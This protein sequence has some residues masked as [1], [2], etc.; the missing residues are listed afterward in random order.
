MIK[1]SKI[2]LLITLVFT[3]LI[4]LLF[5]YPKEG[6]KVFGYEVKFVSFSDYV[7]DVEYIVTN[8]YSAKKSTQTLK[9]VVVTDLDTNS[10]KS[11]SLFSADFIIHPSGFENSM[12]LFY[13]K[14]QNIDNEKESIRIVHFG[15]SQI[16]GDRISNVLRE[17]LQNE[18]GGC[19]V[20]FVPVS[21]SNFGKVTIN[22]TS[23]GWEKHQLFG[24]KQID[25][26]NSFGF[27]GYYH[28]I[29][30][31]QNHAWVKFSGSYNGTENSQKFQNIKLMLSN[32]Q[33]PVDIT[34]KTDT[35]TIEH[36]SLLKQE[37]IY[38]QE[39]K[40]E[41]SLKNSYEID[42]DSEN[43]PDVIGFAMDCEEGISV[44]N[45]P[46]RGSSG[47]S[48]SAKN[49]E[50]LKNQ[51]AHLNVGLVI[52]QFG[53][54]VV[55]YV[56]NDYTYYEKMISRQLKLLKEILPNA[57]ILVVGVSDMSRK[58]D[59]DYESYPNITKIREAQMRAAKSNNC[60]FWDLYNVMGGEN[61]MINWVNAK[62]SLAEK[63]YT[64]FN[65]RG[66]KIVGKKLYNAIYSDYV[67]YQTLNIQ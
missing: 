32:V 4:T 41:G 34:L 63:D 66:A 8:E 30:S 27:L 7:P 46:L 44:D 2:L 38:L 35:G 40:V 22:S 11:D 21:E 24:K 56:V 23:E 59:E 54:N 16:E 20:G 42:F 6:I 58:V 53:V 14:L 64:H 67:E 51:F 26:L 49:I 10:L 13:K 52:Y 43:S 19:G 9:N 61:S 57:A 15:D 12:Y 55:P 60:A 25:P 1:P 36:L 33:Q 39:W 31:N 50:T 45:I 29:A 17:C 3:V 18:F 37:G 28:R 47:I 65:R 48:F 5:V 62:P